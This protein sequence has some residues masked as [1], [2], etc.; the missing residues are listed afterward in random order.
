MRIASV[1][2]QLSSVASDQLGL[3]SR[4]DAAD[5]E[6]GA[7]QLRHLLGMGVIERA[8][9]RVFRFAASSRSWHQDV[10]AACLD[11]GPECVASHRTAAVLHNFDGFR[12]DVIEVLVPMSVRHRRKSV[13]VHHTRVLTALDRARVGLIPVTSRARTLIDLG[14]VV[15]AERVEEA[16]DGAERDGAI[17]RRQLEQR[18]EVLRAPGRNGVG[19]MTQILDRRLAVARLPRSVLERRMIRLLSRAGLPS[20]VGCHPVR[21]ASGARY[22]IDFA[23]LSERIAIE[24]DGHGT[25]ATRSQR[26]AD[27]VRANS[28]EDAG[29]TVRRFTYEQ[30]M[31]EPAA[32]AA[33]VRTALSRL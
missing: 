31:Y 25:H 7:D 4:A 27:N 32:V 1:I 33:A 10:L 11:G 14:A 3:F 18:Y 24:V 28:L 30:I 8:T 5:V 23:Y 29:W 12:A 16:L 9:P 2:A 19:A 15:P 17:R 22:E 6:I 21:G 13:I 26:A 20:P